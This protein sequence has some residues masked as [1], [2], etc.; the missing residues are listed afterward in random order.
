MIKKKWEWKRSENQ[1]NGSLKLKL[2][3]KLIRC[4]YVMLVLITYNKNLLE[5]FLCFFDLWSCLIFIDHSSQSPDQQGWFKVF[6][7]CNSILQ[8]M[9]T[10]DFSF[11][12]WGINFLVRY[13]SKLNNNI[14]IY[15]RNIF[16]I[17]KYL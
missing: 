6:G 2:V 13:E 4:N 11:N 12:F 9:Q 15:I 1:I 16:N 5:Y 14:L 3:M 8:I 10:L 17:F 7:L